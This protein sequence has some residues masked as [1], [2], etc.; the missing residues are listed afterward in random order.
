[1]KKT[2]KMKLMALTCVAL[3]ILDLCW[4]IEAVWQEKPISSLIFSFAFAFMASQARDFQKM[5][6]EED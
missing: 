6:R 5:A 2:L 1:M 4:L 3:A